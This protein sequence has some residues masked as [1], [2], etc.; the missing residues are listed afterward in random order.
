MRSRYDE[1]LSNDADAQQLISS[2]E[3]RFAL[4]TVFHRLLR[5]LFP[6][7]HIAVE[8]SQF[9]FDI[10]YLLEKT[11]FASIWLW[12]HRIGI[13]RTRGGGSPKGRVLVYALLVV[14]SYGIRLFQTSFRRSNGT[15]GPVVVLP[16]PSTVNTAV[17]TTSAALIAGECPVCKRSVTN[18]ATNVASGSVGCFPCLQSYIEEHGTCPGSGVASSV[19]QLRRL[20][21]G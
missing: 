10:A 2:R 3:Q 9:V 11:P 4:Y 19:L 8:G 20:Y 15:G 12:W 1:L 21:E 17:G 6:L 18:P 14:A 7:L 13:R 16:P 5:L